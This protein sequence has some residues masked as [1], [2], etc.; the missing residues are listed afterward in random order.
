MP[1]HH[2]KFSL[3]KTGNV[4]SEP[5]TVAPFDVAGSP[6]PAFVRKYDLQL[7]PKEIQKSVKKDLELL[8]K[9]RFTK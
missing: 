3:S 1:K 4:A 8:K 9:F 5:S 7:T 2:R 6:S